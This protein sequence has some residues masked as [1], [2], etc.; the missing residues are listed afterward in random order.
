ML[1]PEWQSRKARA[2]P[3]RPRRPGLAPERHAPLSSP[4]SSFFV[5]LTWGRREEG[6]RPAYWAQTGSDGY[7]RAFPFPLSASAGEVRRRIRGAALAL[8]EA[9]NVEGHD[10]LPRLRDP[11]CDR[12]SPRPSR[13]AGRYRVLLPGIQ[14][15]K[16]APTPPSSWEQRLRKPKPWIGAK[17][18]TWSRN[19]AGPGATAAPKRSPA[20]RAIVGSKAARPPVHSRHASAC[21][22][23]SRAPTSVSNEDDGPKP[24]KNRMAAPPSANAAD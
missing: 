14:P 13:R 6:P 20:P 4:P 24:E 7:R 1:R 17:G 23:P 11:V 12:R 5:A 3:T 19:A 16:A 15:Q 2:R 8:V 21:P 10:E 22:T 9:V 18:C